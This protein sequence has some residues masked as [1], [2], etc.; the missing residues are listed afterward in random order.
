MPEFEGRIDPGPGLQLVPT[1]S[2]TTKIEP[3]EMGGL[4]DGLR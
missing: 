2:V 4:N 1:Y 3:K